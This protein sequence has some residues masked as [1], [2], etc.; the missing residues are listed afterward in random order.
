MCCTSFLLF[1]LLLLLL[2]L[3]LMCRMNVNIRMYGWWGW[4]FYVSVPFS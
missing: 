3:D 2:L 4:C 1:L